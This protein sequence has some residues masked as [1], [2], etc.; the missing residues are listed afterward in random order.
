MDVVTPVRRY[1]VFLVSLD[2]TQ[3]AEIRK[4]RP[5]VVVSPDEMNRH[6]RTAIVAPMTSTLRDYPSRVATTFQRKKG[7]VALDQIRT[8]DKTRLVRRVG[9]L[10]E[11]TSREIADT[12]QRMFNYD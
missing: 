7:K 2:P 12:L 6:L 5:C 4:T 10:P 1:D 3:G 11:V 9:R 8:V